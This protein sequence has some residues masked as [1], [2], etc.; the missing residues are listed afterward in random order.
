MASLA[1]NLRVA[2]AE[3]EA[4]TA[5]IEFESGTTGTTLGLYLARQHEA[6]AHDQ[7]A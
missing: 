6:K 1:H 7:R 2:A 4:G 5:V 3:R